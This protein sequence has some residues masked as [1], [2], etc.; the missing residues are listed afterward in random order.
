MATP[1]FTP[2]GDFAGTLLQVFRP[3]QLAALLATLL[4][5]GEGHPALRPTPG[6]LAGPPL[7]LAAGAVAVGLTPLGRGRPTEVGRGL[8]FGLAPGA[9]RLPLLRSLEQAAVERAEA[10]PAHGGERPSNQD[11]P[12]AGA[13]ENVDG[14]RG[15]LCPFRLDFPFAGRQKGL[16]LEFLVR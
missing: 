6:Q 7:R 1:C 5:A 11:L 13:T 15:L 8:T 4:T 3:P 9:D 14:H 10:L 12:S 16:T 2:A